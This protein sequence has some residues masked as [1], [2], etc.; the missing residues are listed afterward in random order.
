MKILVINCGSS[1]I[2]Y[3]LFVIDENGYNAELAKGLI[4]RVG[5][6]DAQIAH[7]V[8]SRKLASVKAIRDY[9]TGIAEIASHLHSHHLINDDLA[10]IGHRV[11]HGAEAFRES[12]IIDKAVVTQIEKCSQ[13]AP[14]HNPANLAGIKACQEIFPK[15]PQ[16]A[17]FDTAF[18]Q[19]LSPES[20]LYALPYDWYEKYRVRRYG[21]HGTSHRYVSEKAA[22][23]LHKPL[24][25]CNFVTM[26]LGNGCSMAAIKQGQAIDTTMGLT[27]L[28]GLVMGS[29]C[30]DIDTAIVFHMLAVSPMALDQVRDS[31]EKKSGL[32]GISG[33]S[34]DMRDVFEAADKGNEQAKLALQIFARRVRKYLG[35]YIMEI[36]S[37]DALVFTGGIG[38]NAWRMREMILADL[39]HLGIKINPEKNQNLNLTSAGAAIDT[40]EGKLAVLVIPTNEE[41]AIAHDTCKL[42]ANVQKE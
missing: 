26:H 5:T 8:D 7:Q 15:T 33:V 4:E 16:I 24:N 32:V 31:L 3:R 18:F 12:V 2:K 6:D 25:Q 27:P 38:E 1:S 10:G 42:V 13:L 21:F 40:H 30:G 39:E 22:E 14:L 20:F 11:V 29:R 19:T 9:K 37:P 35:A 41:L 23:F 28:E 34:R 17:V 36:G